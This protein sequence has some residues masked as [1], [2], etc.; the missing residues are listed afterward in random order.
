MEN[1]NIVELSIEDLLNGDNQYVIPPY[2]RNYAWGEEQITQL[3][4]DIIDYFPKDS[5]TK[6]NYYIGT[7]IVYERR[8]NN[9]MIYE[10]IDGQQRLTTLSILSSV[11]KNKTEY[12]MNWFKKLNLVFDSRKNST[13]TLQAVYDDH[14]PSNQEYSIG[15]KDAYELVDKVLK[16]KLA[17]YN[18]TFDK[19]AEF[20]YENVKILRV[21]VP[22]DTDLNHYF[23]I[24]NSRGEQL[25][26]H[27]VLKAKLLEV[28]NSISNTEEKE[29][30]KNL[31][32]QIWEACSN[33][34]KYVQY[35]F[36]ISQRNS[37]FGQND[38]NQFS[39]KNFD[40]LYSKISFDSKTSTESL[41]ELSIDDIISYRTYKSEN[42]ELEDSPDRFTSVI[43]FQNFLLHVL[44]VQT[45]KDIPLDDKRLLEIFKSNL[46]ECKDEESKINFSKNFAFNLIKCKFLFDKYII[47]RE[48]IGGIDKWSLKRF[49]WY[50]KNKVSY[51]NTFSIEENEHDLDDNRQTLMLLS[52]YHVS[53][54]TMV[55]KHWLNAALYYLFYELNNKFISII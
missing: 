33:M 32:N 10:T 37:V 51:V 15:I 28:F 18:L 34:E 17:E 35:G 39:H 6:K 20:L 4:Q 1:N 40:D 5:Q 53:V 14:F 21:P 12:P 31:F 19:F 48:F 23:E 22:N 38:W 44:R 2:Q 54:P 25:E 45:K 42:Q 41:E 26:K 30:S 47:K 52:M 29:K 7:L 50:D 13:E 3:I 55:Y 9:T 16:I 27:E 46:E 49:K 11:I 8:Q 43:N 24:M 36:S